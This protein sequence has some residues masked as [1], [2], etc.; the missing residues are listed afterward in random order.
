LTKLN[1]KNPP[2]II[3]GAVNHTV[4]D[5]CYNQCLHCKEISDLHCMCTINYDKALERVQ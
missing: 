3:T 5:S 2:F 4:L 1:T